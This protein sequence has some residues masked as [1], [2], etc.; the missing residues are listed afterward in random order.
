MEVLNGY[1]RSKPIFGNI[2]AEKFNNSKKSKFTNT[3]EEPIAYTI[4]SLIHFVILLFALYLAWR[5][6]A[7][8]WGY[9]LALLFPEFYIIYKLVTDGMCGLVFKS[10]S[11]QVPMPQVNV[12]VTYAQAPAPAPRV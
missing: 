1:I 7:G 6:N 11:G 8:F 12:P 5:C 4:G 2:L 9:F 10:S 3:D